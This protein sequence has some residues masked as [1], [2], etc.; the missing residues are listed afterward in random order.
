MDDIGFPPG[1]G[2]VK[3]ISQI[4]SSII[5]QT[6][7]RLGVETGR[8]IKFL[9]CVAGSQGGGDCMHRQRMAACNRPNTR[10]AG[11]KF[12]GSFSQKRTVCLPYLPRCLLLQ[13]T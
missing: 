2:A 4:S 5:L 7:R 13:T 10:I 12:F 3:T 1:F 8:G 9:F 11:P 6:L